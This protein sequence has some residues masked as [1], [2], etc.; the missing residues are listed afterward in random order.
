M[1]KAEGSWS[2]PLFSNERQWDINYSDILTKLIQYAGRYCESYASDLFIIWNY[3]VERKLKNPDLESF[4]LK[5]GFREM[6][7]D[8]EV[9]SD[10]ERNIVTRHLKENHYYYRKVVTLEVNIND[11]KIEMILK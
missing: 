11:N 10:P 9:S 5:F 2:T 3:C 1:I 4:T 7:V 8:H 6:G